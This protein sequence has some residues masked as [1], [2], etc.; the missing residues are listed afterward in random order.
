MSIVCGALQDSLSWP[1]G[2]CL[3]DEKPNW[4]AHGPKMWVTENGNAEN[5]TCF[6]NDGGGSTRTYWQEDMIQSPGLF[7]F[8]PS[9]FQQ[10]P[11]GHPAGMTISPHTFW[12]TLIPCSFPSLSKEMNKNI[13]TI[14]IPR[15]QNPASFKLANFRFY[16]EEHML[17]EVHD[18]FPLSV[19]QGINVILVFPYVELLY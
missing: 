12:Q 10:T 15:K 11:D 5:K 4:A 6:C 13:K 1:L 18:T 14:I 16:R 17:L 19:I 8:P 3:R 2:P 9:P 7:F